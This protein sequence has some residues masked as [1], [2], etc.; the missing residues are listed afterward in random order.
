MTFKEWI[1]LHTGPIDWVSAAQ[2]EQI[3]GRSAFAHA[4]NLGP[5]YEK[6][7][8]AQQTGLPAEKE[9]EFYHDFCTGRSAGEQFPK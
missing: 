6:F 8:A 2:V 9:M 4:P 5:V 7:F 1:E 3:F